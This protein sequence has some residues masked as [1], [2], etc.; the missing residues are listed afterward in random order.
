MHLFLC[1]TGRAAETNTVSVQQEASDVHIT[2]SDRFI[3]LHCTWT[4]GQLMMRAENTDFCI[5]PQRE[6]HRTRQDVCVCWDFFI[7]DL[8]LL[9]W[10]GCSSAEVRSPCSPASQLLPQLL[11]WRFVC[12]QSTCWNVLLGLVPFPAD[13]SAWR[14]S[15][16]PGN[17]LIVGDRH[18]EEDSEMMA[19]HPPIHIPTVCFYHLLLAGHAH[20]DT[21]RT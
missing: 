11:R 9:M 19:H 15:W 4:I 1:L 10:R 8:F 21:Y 3:I 17:W 12:N 20:M 14:T 18:N 5:T 6:L 13:L 7:C 16:E 2:G